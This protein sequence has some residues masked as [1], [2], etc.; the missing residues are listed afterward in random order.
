M[1]VQKNMS[2]KILWI[3]LAV[4]LIGGGAFFAFKKFQKKTP[5]AKVDNVKVVST[6][7]KQQNNTNTKN[8]SLDE[9]EK[10]KEEQKRINEKDRLADEAKK[11]EEQKR[12]EEL[13]AKEDAKKQAE[14]KAKEDA[15]KQAELKAKEDAKKQA[16]LKAKED[17][18]K[19]NEDKKV[20]KKNK[21][22]KKSKGKWYFVNFNKEYY[23]LEDEDNASEITINDVCKENE[24]VTTYCSHSEDYLSKSNAKDLGEDLC[25]DGEKCKTG[26]SCLIWYD[27]TQDNGDV[28]LKTATY[29][30][31]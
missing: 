2:K 26:E 23:A 24:G 6:D 4:L 10:L 7:K 25:N 30:C 3:I 28:E 16:E 15:K 22:V 9:I 11:A 20:E 18:K 13:K 8:K 21:T 14:L 17:A 27:E 1:I 12:Q 31:E 29:K 19:Q 5:V